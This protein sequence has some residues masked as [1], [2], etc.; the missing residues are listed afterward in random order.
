MK[1]RNHGAHEKLL[2]LLLIILLAGCLL[3]NPASRSLA[4]MHVP[5]IDMTGAPPKP[6]QTVIITRNRIAVLGNSREVSVR[7][8]RK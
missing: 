5:V 4:I 2:T 1:K 3:H 7:K 6:D 8:I